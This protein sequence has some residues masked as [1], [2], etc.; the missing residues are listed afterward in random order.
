[1]FI[2]MVSPQNF[3]QSRQQGLVF[4]GQLYGDAVP[5]CFQAGIIG[6]GADLDA[7]FQQRLPELPVR[8][9]QNII[10]VGTNDPQPQFPK[11][12]GQRRPLLP[13]GLFRLFQKGGL[14]QRRHPGLLGGDGHIPGLDGLAH[15]PEQ[16][17]IPAKTIAQPQPRHAVALRKG[18]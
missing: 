14:F 9:K 3:F 10:R 16:R 1:M 6:A 8:I 11:P 4:P 18:F 7:F 15:G 13:D 5:A 12:S 2:A 17:G